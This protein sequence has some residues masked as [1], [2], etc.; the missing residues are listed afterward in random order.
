MSKIL[1][2]GD[3]HLKINNLEQ[4]LNFLNW[5]NEI[6]ELYKPDV[7]CNL[8]DTFDSHAVL[9]AEMLTEF[10]YHVEKVTKICPYWYVLGNHD[11]S[12]P[13]SS[14]YHALQAYN[15]PNLTVFDK[16]TQLSGITIVPYVQTPADFPLKTNKIVITH[17]TFIGA[18]YGFKK[19]EYGVDA[20]AV[21]AEII[22]SGHIHKRQTFGKVTYPGTP[23]A[24]N[25]NDI[26]EVK[27]VMLFDTA[28]YQQT[29]IESPFTKW[30]GLQLTIDQTFDIESLHKTLHANLDL[31]NKWVLT[32]SGPKVELV[33]YFQ[34]SRYVQLT[35]DKNV[36]LKLVSSDLDK[37]QKLQIKASKDSE[38]VSEYVS[39]VYAGSIDR[40][41]IIDKAQNILKNLQ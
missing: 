34:S 26:D 10:K 31:I 22:I 38:I 8:G 37:K 12:S 29:F 35:A 16:I 23:Y 1:F 40:A 32:I 11:Q 9:R 5:I 3:P 4:G 20:D 13:K 2:I 41:L 25:A 28:T 18:D 39:K 27:G 36:I 6:T 19:E 33:K 24:Y 14:K 17:N 7:V 15:I 21:S 30:K